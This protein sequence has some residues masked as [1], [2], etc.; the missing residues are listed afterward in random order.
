VDRP[1]SFDINLRLKEKFMYVITGAS[2]NVGNIVA[3]KLLAA[4]QQVRVI[5]R[6]ADRLQPLADSG[7]E[8]FVCDLT[9]TEA[10]T[11][12]F[13]GTRAVYAMIP[14]E[15]T[16]QDYRAYQ[17]RVTDAIATAIEKAKVEYVVS[18][19]S[20]GADKSERNGPIAGLHY[21]E[22]RLNEISGLNALHLRCG[23]FMENTLEQ[24][25]IIKAMGA[26][27]DSLHPD[28]KVPMIATRDIGTTV[29]EALLSLDFNGKQTR[30]LPGQ[31]DI[32]LA[33]A[34]ATIGK[35]IGKPELTY[36]QLP[37]E[38]LRAALIQHGMSPNVADLILEMSAALNSGHI[39]AL[40]KR[41]AENT[42]ATSYETFVAEEFVPRYQGKST[43]A[44]H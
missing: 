37:D 23:Y 38:Q 14:T 5:G 10:L 6:S 30:E 7:A 34:T 21:L 29:A 39:V 24:I 18:L 4:G 22:Q 32:S 8:A 13:T 28:L 19:S 20:I 15:V 3:R 25:G 17:D 42:A 31:R 26:A 12:A 16:S 36:V 43:S 44:A 11:K 35:A 2:G 9:D 40:E 1:S 33:E 41:A 27:A